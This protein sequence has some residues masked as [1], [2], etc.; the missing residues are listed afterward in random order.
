MLLSM[1]L[2]QNYHSRAIFHFALQISSAEKPAQEK[3]KLTLNMH[4]LSRE[5]QVFSYFFPQL[6]LPASHR[7]QRSFFQQMSANLSP[8]LN[9]TKC[10]Y[11]PLSIHHQK[12]H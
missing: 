7:W 5:C 9:V 4:L 6:L 11:H 3:K 12:H 2:L 1:V 10:Y 8:L